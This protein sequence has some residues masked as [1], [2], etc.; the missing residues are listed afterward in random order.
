MEDLSSLIWLGLGILWFLTRFIR[1]GAKKVAQT[2]TKRPRPSMPPAEARPT[3]LE[4]LPRLTGRGH[5]G[6]KPIVPR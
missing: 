5:K 3:R 2:Q 6:P 4:S 1:R